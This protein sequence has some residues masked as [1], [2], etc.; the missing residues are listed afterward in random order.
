MSFKIMDLMVDVMLSAAEP[1]CPNSGQTA[2]CPTGEKDRGCPNSGPGTHREP[3]CPNSGP[4][5]GRREEPG[6]PNSGVTGEEKSP[7][8]HARAW[9]AAGLP[10]L[11]QQLRATLGAQA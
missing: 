3:G 6:C 10:E 5:P 9:L 1:G 2:G 7:R 11:R 4:D 8:R